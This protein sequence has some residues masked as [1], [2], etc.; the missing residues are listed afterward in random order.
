MKKI[1]ILGGTG[2]LIE[3]LKNKD[4]EVFVTSRSEH[5][6]ECNIHYIKGDAKDIFF[7]QNL[8]KD[9][10]D[11]VI[12]FM[13][14]KTYEFLDR[15]KFILSSTKQYIFLSS[16]RV[17]ADNG[18][19]PLDENC[20][21]LLNVSIDEKFLR[22][23]EYSLEKARQEQILCDSNF[24]NYTII[25]PSITFSKYRFQ[26]GTLE[27]NIIIPR[28]LRNKPVICPTEMLDKYAAISWAGDV[29]KMIR[30]LIL[31]KNA[32]TEAFNVA[33]SEKLTWR[34]VVLLYQKYIGL[35]IYE[36][37][38]QTYIKVVKGPYQIKYDRMFNRIIS[39]SKILKI[40]NCTQKDL[41]PVRDALF[42]EL[43]DISEKI[44]KI[45]FNKRLSKRMDRAILKH[46]I[47]KFFKK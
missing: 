10:F 17:Y 13:V 12:D 24:K 41:K 1:L 5:Q 19:E 23:D 45:H 37:D 22:M 31:N 9:Q 46:R 29:A 6:D 11:C 16:Y 32:Y 28:A 26:L 47:I 8:L 30:A 7:L 38:L 39:N 20:S 44:K 42:D 36:V 40:M 21:K 2:Y 15:Y 33:T 18:L 25:R 35:K 3:E 14:Y 34:D 43:Q 4:Y 27:A